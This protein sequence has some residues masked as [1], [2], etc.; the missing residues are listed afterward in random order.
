[1]YL[2]KWGSSCVLQRRG[3]MYLGDREMQYQG[4]RVSFR[5]W[6]WNLKRKQILLLEL[7]L[8]LWVVL[9]ECKLGI[10]R[11]LPLASDQLALF[12]SLVLSGCLTPSFPFL[13]CKQALL[14]MRSPESLWEFLIM[15]KLHGFQFFLHQNGLLFSFL[16][17]NFRDIPSCVTQLLLESFLSFWINSMS[18]LQVF[19]VV[20]VLLAT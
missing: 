16:S 3:T 11:K 20:C 1:M 15:K 4:S 19:H 2:L 18:N 6:Q 10:F 5:K 9:F 7:K 17:M 8:S 12:G 13:F 14:M